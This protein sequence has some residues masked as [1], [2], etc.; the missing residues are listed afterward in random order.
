MLLLTQ[1]RSLH[2][3]KYGNIY[4]ADMKS[5]HKK[6]LPG[7]AASYGGY[8]ILEPVGN[9]LGR[10]RLAKGEDEPGLSGRD[11]SPRACALPRGQLEV[12]IQDGQNF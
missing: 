6:Q 7:L 10:S 4:F 12:L 2:A 1:D 5:P 3:P 9:G 8:A 11:R